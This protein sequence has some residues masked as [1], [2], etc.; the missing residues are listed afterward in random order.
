MFESALAAELVA[1]VGML[2]LALGALLGLV[3]WVRRGHRALPYDPAMWQGRDWACPDCGAPMT[4]GWVMLGKGAIFS[5]RS[6]GR[7]GFFAHIGSA[8]PNTISMH[9]PPAVNLAWHCDRCRLLLV[10]HDKLVR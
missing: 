10:D 9:V 7:P 3:V 5:P 4:Q 2:V 1:V 6:Q 8:L